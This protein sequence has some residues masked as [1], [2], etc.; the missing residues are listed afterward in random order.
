LPN[1]QAASNPSQS[2]SATGRLRRWAQNN[3]A[4]AV[5]A[6]RAWFSMREARTLQGHEDAIYHGPTFHLPRFSGPSVVTI[7]DLSIYSWAHC[8]PPGRVHNMRRAIAK[9]VRQA[10]V[11]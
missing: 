6:H 2:T 1:G 11:I 5:R 8:H 9:A 7:H 4:I 3:S 10:D